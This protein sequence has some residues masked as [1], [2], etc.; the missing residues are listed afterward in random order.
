MDLSPG[1]LRRKIMV[2]QEN[3]NQEAQDECDKHDAGNCYLCTDSEIND[4]C[5]ECDEP[6]NGIVCVNCEADW[7]VAVEEENL[8]KADYCNGS[9]SDS[10]DS[11]ANW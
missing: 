5:E 8:Y 2:C 10:D 1:A 11:Y 4:F 7:D 9:E 6:T 3:V